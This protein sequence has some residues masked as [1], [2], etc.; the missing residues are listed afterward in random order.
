MK[1]AMNFRGKRAEHKVMQRD[2]FA[3]ELRGLA[4][5]GIVLVNA[6]F[7]GISWQ[8]LTASSMP[9]PQDQILAFIVAAFFQAKFYLIF[10][11]LFGYSFNYFQKISDDN[12]HKRF[13]RRLMVIGTF[14]FLHA[15]LFF[16][17]DILLLYAILGLSL[18]WLKDKKGITILRIVGLYLLLWLLIL[19]AVI[20]LVASDASG[21]SVEQVHQLT[22]Q[23]LRAGSFLD[24]FLARINV[25]P[26]AFTFILVLNGFSTLAMMGLGLLAGRVRLLANTSEHEQLWFSGKI[27]GLAVGLPSGL[28]SAWL[29]V[30]P[31]ANIALP[32]LRET[33]G[34]VLGFA[35]APFL[36]WGYIALLVAIRKR[37]PNVLQFFRS[38]G[39]MSMTCYVGESLLLSL[40]FCG[41]GLGYFGQLTLTSVTAIA[42]A[43]WFTI[44][45][46]AKFWLAKFWHGPLEFL[47]KMVIR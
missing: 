5:L 46:F 39:R 18:I 15:S 22:D 14:G 20:G 24:A 31:G 37:Y 42:I 35:T 10:G 34:V 6:P 28:L 44:D 17:G 21:A 45:I 3:D 19:T 7:L 8:G 11:F 32:G 40:I 2:D 4:L 47:L 33:A 36:A 30:G 13:Y 12:S 41:Y 26:S 23:V 43:A 27:L 25:W 1:S 29:Y 9:A 38:S 16:V